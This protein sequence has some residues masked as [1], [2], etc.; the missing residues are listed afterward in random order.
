M[1]RK[2]V[3]LMIAGVAVWIAGAAGALSA[4]KPSRPL[5]EQ[6]PALCGDIDK[7]AARLQK[8]GI[9]DSLEKSICERIGKMSD[10]KRQLACYRRLSDA[11]LSVRFEYVAEFPLEE[12]PL[13]MDKADIDEERARLKYVH[14]RVVDIVS[15]TIKRSMLMT[16]MPAEEI[17]NQM[18]GLFEKMER[19]RRRLNAQ[20]VAEFVHVMDM[21]EREFDSVSVH[22]VWQPNVEKCLRERFEK[23]VGRPLRTCDEVRNAHIRKYEG[24][25]ERARR[26]E[27]L[28]KME[29]MSR[30]REDYRKKM[31]LPPDARIPEPGTGSWRRLTGKKPGKVV[32]PP[33]ET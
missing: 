25:D 9:T 24:Y 14:S 6:E 4:E 11:V 18:F 5:E 20:D 27:I 3:K 8:D 30:L 7:L 22:H 13:L 1:K 32:L 33:S 29:L 17:L 15:K 10:S 21:T 16:R 19:E 2:I 28:K 12:W 26:K 23:I 31:N